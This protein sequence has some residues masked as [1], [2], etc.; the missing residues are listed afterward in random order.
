MYLAP[1]EILSAQLS[2]R[3]AQNSVL[4][5]GYAVYRGRNV[6]QALAERMSD[7]A[8]LRVRMFLVRFVGQRI[9]RF[10]ETLADTG[11][12]GRIL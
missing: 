3:N 12:F 1:T 5:A 6:F 9:S 4:L 8:A 10:F 2:L 7:V 11:Y